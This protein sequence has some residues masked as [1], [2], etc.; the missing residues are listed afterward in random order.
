VEMY[1]SQDVLHE[2]YLELRKQLAADRR[3]DLP[4]PPAKGTLVL[5]D[6][7]DALYSFS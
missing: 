4:L 6:T 7:L 5:A 2:L 1:E 3:D